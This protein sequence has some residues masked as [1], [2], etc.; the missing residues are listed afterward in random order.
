MLSNS[1]PALD[2]RIHTREGAVTPWLRCPATV[3]DS[4]SQP[5]L[6]IPPLNTAGFSGYPPG[7]L[8][9]MYA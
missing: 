6:T 7:T 1:V 2:T 4:D 9:G 8:P 5:R 3:S